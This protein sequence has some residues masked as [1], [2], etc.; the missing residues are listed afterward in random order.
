MSIHIL[1]PIGVAH[2]P[3]T[4]PFLVMAQTALRTAGCGGD[5]NWRFEYRLESDQI[6]DVESAMLASS[7]AAPTPCADVEVS[8]RPADP[9]CTMMFRGDGV[10]PAPTGA[11]GTTCVGHLIAWQ[12]DSVVAM[13][14]IVS[15][16]RTPPLDLAQT[17]AAKYGV[18]S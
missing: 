11:Y 14:A 3:L 4:I 15:R 7:I 2:D 12:F 16:R 17:I 6:E 5:A 8:M 18:R 1:P 9:P 10:R 13:I